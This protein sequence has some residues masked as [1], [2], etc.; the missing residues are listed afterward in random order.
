MLI[1]VLHLIEIQS[2]YLDLTAGVDERHA[3]SPV[4]L[5]YSM[6][7]RI[8]QHLYQ[9]AFCAGSYLDRLTASRA[10]RV[11]CICGSTPSMAVVER[12]P[13]PQILMS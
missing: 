1:T 11:N 6:W 2:D 4:K 13:H 10:L 8:E 5:E 7:S 12:E 3:A 9:T